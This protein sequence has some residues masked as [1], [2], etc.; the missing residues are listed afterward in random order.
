MERI[1]TF[2]NEHPGTVLAG[3]AIAL[4]L[5]TSLAPEDSAAHQMSPPA[6]LERTPII[7]DIFTDLM[8]YTGEIHAR[9]ILRPL[10]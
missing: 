3:L 5:E 10:T 7:G 8:R 2:I 4:C 1:S 6:V 9:E